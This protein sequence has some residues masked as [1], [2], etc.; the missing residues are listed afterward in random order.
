MSEILLVLYAAAILCIK[1]IRTL[2]LIVLAIQGPMVFG[3]AVYDGLQH[4]L[5]Q[6]LAR[7]INIFLWL[8]IA[9]IF[10][11][12]IGKVQQEMI[13]LDISQIQ[14]AGDTFFSPTDTAYLIFLC[15]GI[16]GYF[17]VPSVANYV[18][19]A[20]GGYGLL[21]RVTSVAN[22]TVNTAAT[23]VLNR[24]A[25]LGERSEQARSNIRYAPADFMEGW[26]SAGSS[27]Q[28]DKLSGK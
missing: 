3:F 21:N 17:C 2:Y 9:N 6:W 19:H 13:R 18:I 15:I 5:T 4:T 7:Y 20:N 12:I 16:V 14:S 26:K 11:S 23:M 27:H 28:Q 10:G 8:P 25:A 22:S 1:T 24:A